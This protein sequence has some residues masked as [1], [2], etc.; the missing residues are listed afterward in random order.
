M[1]SPVDQIKER[2]LIVDFLSSYL[3]VEK[4][5]KNYKAKCPFHNEKTP[6]FY[7]SPERGTYYCFGCNAKGDIFTFVE[8][9]EGLDF[10]GALQSL[11][12]KAGVDLKKIKTKAGSEKERLYEIMEEARKFFFEFLKK[13]FISPFFFLNILKKK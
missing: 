1:N 11:A 4:S 6:S 9:F 12:E 2:L 5:G 8:E 10:R 7:I 3:R 13:I